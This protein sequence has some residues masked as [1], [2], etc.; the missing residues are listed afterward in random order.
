M[1]NLSL[2]FLLLMAVQC[3]AAQSPDT[4]Y[5][6]IEGVR[7]HTVLTIP[8][9]AKEIPL[10]II[11]AGSGPTDLNGNQIMMQ[12]NS[13]RYLSDALVAN[14]IATLRF[15]KRGIAGSSYEQF[16]ES[17]LT[18]DRYAEDVNEL[19][20][21]G[22]KCGYK[23][24]YVVG[25]SEGSLVGLLA[26]KE[27][28]V[29]GF[30]SLCGAGNAADQ[31]LK[32]Q[33]KTKLPDA[34]YNEAAGMIDSLKNEQTVH[35]VPPY[36]YSLFRPSVQPYMMSWFRYN[37]SE[38]I[39]ALNCPSLIVQAEKDIQVDMEEAQLLHAAAPGAALIVVHKMNHVLK[40]IAGDIA[41]NWAA[42][43][44]PDLPVNEELV[45]SIVAFIN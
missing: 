17:N 19:I 8:N 36:F 38:L 43:S 30:V 28:Q 40:T 15:D 18:I 7:L 45:K 39:A 44:N 25:H 24:I 35:S 26:L 1:K 22:R 41:E 5:V 32:K 16:S 42:Y 2:S 31:I 27:Q 23:D 12:N 13:L 3:I 37:P 29:S 11:I 21:Y 4:A 14:D 10:A 20:E 33:L 34:I 6:Q 9:D